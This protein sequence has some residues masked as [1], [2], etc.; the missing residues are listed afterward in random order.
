[1]RKIGWMIVLL[2][3]AAPHADSRAQSALAYKAFNPFDGTWKGVFKIYAF[4]G[5][6]QQVIEVEQ[7]YFW[8]GD[9]QRVVIKDTYPDG[10]IEISKGKNFTE[11]YTI[12]C[13]VEK[14]NGEVTIHNGKLSDDKLF[15]SRNLPDKGIQE[16][17]KEYIARVNGETVYFIDG[18]GIYTSKGVQSVLLFEGRYVKQK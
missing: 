12:T 3:L 1:M 5:E 17:F 6:L 13:R 15:W 10:R 14:A 8:D 18:I 11:G 9:T 4:E 7:H 2:L 16:S